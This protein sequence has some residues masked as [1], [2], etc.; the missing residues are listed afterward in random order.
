MSRL[1][2]AA[3][4]WSVVADGEVPVP[5]RRDDFEIHRLA[6][7]ETQHLGRVNNDIATPVPNAALDEHEPSPTSV[8]NELG[9]V[10]V[11][12]DPRSRKARCG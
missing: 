9:L 5:Y 11:K 2:V 4:R 8:V 10:W 1:R 7:V 3:L 6:G 12:R